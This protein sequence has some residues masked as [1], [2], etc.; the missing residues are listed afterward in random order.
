MLRAAFLG[1]GLMGTPMAS[2]ILAGGHLRSVWNRNIFRT[3]SLAGA[4]VRVLDMPSQAGTDQLDVVCL[5]LADSVAVDEVMFGS[6]G[7]AGG[8]VGSP[9]LVIDFTTCSPGATRI[10][11]RKYRDMTGGAWL[12]APVS[13]GV[14]RAA[15]G[16]LIVLCGGDAADF[17]RARS[18][19]DCVAA[20]SSHVGPQG[21]GQTAKLVGQLIV[22]PT[23]V[24]IAE[25]L[26][27][28]GSA[29]LDPLQL[30][31][32][33][34]GGM[35]DSPALQLFGRRMA[36]G[37]TEPRIGAIG[38]MLKD[39]EA[40]VTMAHLHN[41]RLPVAEAALEVYRCTCQQGG[42]SQELNALMT[43]FAPDRP[44]PVTPQTRA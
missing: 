33:F 1:L 4:G 3:S 43:H 41:V 38:T 8:I 24:A 32:V 28:A 31:D 37:Q 13:G 17:E 18:I 19:L 10:L 6:R 42:S 29:G 44:A 11:A 34:T 23:L 40:A 27:T 35:A 21:C 36:T 14:V 30:V 25:A 39:I 9:P 16:A 12:D 2:R 5:C 20:R 7:V 22:A 26:A 15:A